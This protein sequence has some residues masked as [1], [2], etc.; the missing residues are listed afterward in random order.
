MRKCLHCSHCFMCVIAALACTLRTHPNLDLSIQIPICISNSSLNTSNGTTQRHLYLSICT[1]K[2]APSLHSP[3]WTMIV[4]CFSLPSQKFSHYLWC[5]LKLYP[6]N[7]HITNPH[8]FTS[9]MSP[10]RSPCPNPLTHTLGEVFIT[11]CSDKAVINQIY[12]L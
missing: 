10:T 5:L 9:K 4:N 7:Q 2:H 6:V 8:S 3:P 12:A 11:S 1:H